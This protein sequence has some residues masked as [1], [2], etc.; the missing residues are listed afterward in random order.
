[1]KLGGGR[2]RA[3]TQVKELSPEIT[4]VSVADTVHLGAGRT[5][6]TVLARL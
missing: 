6:V 1:M 4:I 5:L 2:Y 3:A